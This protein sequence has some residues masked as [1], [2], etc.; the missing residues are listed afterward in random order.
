MKITSHYS[1]ILASVAALQL[2]QVQAGFNINEITNGA[3]IEALIAA[4]PPEVQNAVTSVVQG[5]QTA[6]NFAD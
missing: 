1:F 3:I 4:T 2:A 6:A 5:V